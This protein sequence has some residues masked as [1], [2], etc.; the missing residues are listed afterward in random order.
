LADS[1]IDL[2]LTAPAIRELPVRGRAACQGFVEAVTYVPATQ[3]P[4]FSA[5][6][7]DVDPYDRPQQVKQTSQRHAP[8]GRDRLR[9]V[10]MGRRQVPG[11]VAGTRLRFE[12]MVADRDGVATIFNPRYE[13]IAQQEL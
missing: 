1:S 10:W 6:V 4:S 2:S 3:A 11:I 13:I 8:A 12:G 9:L 5:V 7:T